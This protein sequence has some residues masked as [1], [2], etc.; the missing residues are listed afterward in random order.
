MELLSF[1]G[2]IELM[3]VPGKKHFEVYLDEREL[4]KAFKDK[5]ENW[6]DLSGN[7]DW[8]TVEIIGNAIS[9]YYLEQDTF[10]RK[11]G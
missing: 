3:V 1:G 11:A 10:Y 7:L 4:C 2:N 8:Y 9:L 6:E 5:D